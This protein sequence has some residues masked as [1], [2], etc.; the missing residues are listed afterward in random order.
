MLDAIITKIF[1]W[2]NEHRME[3]ASGSLE[4]KM[5]TL[6][7]NY[8]HDLLV[9]AEKLKVVELN[10]FDREYVVTCDKGVDY[11]VSLLLKT[12]SCKI[13]DIQ[14]Y[15]CI[16]ALAAFINIMDD[17]YHVCFCRICGHISTT[18]NTKLVLWSSN[19]FTSKLNEN[20]Y[21]ELLTDK[22]VLLIIYT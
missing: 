6:V 9:F 13:F 5:V 12:C 10:S 18:G 11:T 19:L 3:A 1:V 2:F 4:N 20:E 22:N 21:S 16:H 14:K 15:P 7:E 8:L 17:E